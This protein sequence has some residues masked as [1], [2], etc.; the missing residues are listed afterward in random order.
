[1]IADRGICETLISKKE[2]KGATKMYFA[3]YYCVVIVLFK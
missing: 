1:M 3:H 2:I